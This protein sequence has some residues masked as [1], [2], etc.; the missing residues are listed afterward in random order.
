MCKT[1]GLSSLGE[2]LY[3]P[4]GTDLEEMFLVLYLVNTVAFYGNS[5][6]KLANRGGS[7]DLHSM[8]RSAQ[9]SRGVH[10]TASFN[11]YVKTNKIS[12]SPNH[13]CNSVTDEKNI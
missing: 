3:L 8:E 12:V 6:I 9:F 11:L 7:Q 10:G 2:V 13:L 1:A 4:G 5:F